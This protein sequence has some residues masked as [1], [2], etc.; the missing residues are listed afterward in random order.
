M[1]LEFHPEARDEFVSA[2]DYY[3]AAVPGLGDRFL[4]AVQRT[5][6]MIL[7][8][9]TAGTPRRA[10]ARRVLVTGFPYDVVYQVREDLVEV[11]AVAHQRRR[12]NY[13]RPRVAG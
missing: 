7:R 8:H 3:N 4:L 9:P 6:D 13:W 11:L 10:T 1:R 5:T 12:P 2:A